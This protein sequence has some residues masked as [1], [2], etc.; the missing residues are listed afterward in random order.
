MTVHAP[1]HHPFFVPSYTYSEAGGKWMYTLGM[2]GFATK[3]EAQKDFE[4]RIEGLRLSGLRDPANRKR[5]THAVL[6]AMK[7][8]TVEEVAA[9]MS[10]V[11]FTGGPTDRLAE[12]V[13]IS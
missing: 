10:G 4:Q 12:E 2:S 1:R 6:A 5:V 9:V 13:E 7:R 3:A 8:M 11:G